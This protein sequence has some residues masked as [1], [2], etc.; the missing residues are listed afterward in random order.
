VYIPIDQQLTE[1]S[2]LSLGPLFKITFNGQTEL[3]ACSQEIVNELCDETRFYKAV[4]GGI[5]KLR[6]GTGDG[7]FTAYDGEEG[8][9]IAHRIL[10]P[11]FG[12]IAIRDTFP[13][14]NDLA[15]QLC[16]KW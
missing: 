3:V 12:P 16:L 9:E 2:S 4:S 14:M 1:S 15:N 10:M 13:Q 11:A 7:L 8:W 5:E 6:P